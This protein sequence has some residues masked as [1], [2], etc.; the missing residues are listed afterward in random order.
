MDTFSDNRGPEP[1]CV[2]VGTMAD[3][4]RLVFTGLERTGGVVVHD[5]TDL[6]DVKFQD[7]LNVRNWGVDE[8]PERVA[9]PE[10]Y[11]LYDGFTD[12]AFI[13][14]AQVRCATCVAY[15]LA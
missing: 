15:S 14:A 4:R 2:A 3:G 5:A 12:L 11:M 10:L 1:E 13:A 6:K 7:L 8:A 9:S